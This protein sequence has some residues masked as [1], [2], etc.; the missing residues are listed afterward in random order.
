ME[1]LNRKGVV[2][3]EERFIFTYAD[4]LKHC[5]NL[6][7]PEAEEE[8]V[9]VEE[10]AVEYI[11]DEEEKVEN[12]KKTGDKKHDKI[13]KDI[14][15]NKKEMAKFLNYFM[16][17]KILPEELENQNPNYITNNFKY[18]QIDIL[19]KIK[20][21]QIYIFVEHQTKVDYSMPYRIFNYCMEIIR[22]AVVE[23][24]INKATYKYPIVIPI[25]LYTGNQRWIA[26]TSFLESQV[27]DKNTNFK[28]IDIKYKLIDINK[29]EEQEL[30]D[31]NTM[32]ANVMILEKCKNNED[33]IN[34]LKVII[35][36]LKDDVQKDKLKR[37]VLYLYKDIEEND[38]EQIFKMVE[39][40]ESEETMS[41]IRER[42]SEEFRNERKKARAQGLAEGTAEGRAEGRA[43]GIEQGRA[44]GVMQGI[45]QTIE[46]MIKMNFKDEI[47]REATG[48]KKTEI[49]RIRKQMMRV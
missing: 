45:A 47:I 1:K 14:L 49:D 34:C 37:I 43:Q 16:K 8:F 3:I 41:T 10:D 42:I 2:F 12:Q 28:A 7:Y 35:N 24:E 6:R 26:P 32:L 19:Y 31:R 5:N 36:N 29:Y 25:V 48:A 9:S 23:K 30:L 22:G 13:F 17:Y 11:L 33:A 46:K 39:E 21:K 18:K 4:Y 38:I 40:S 15:Q 44:Q 20:E 27:E